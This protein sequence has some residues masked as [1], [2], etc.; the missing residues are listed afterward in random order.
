VEF[1]WSGVGRYDEWPDVS[2]ALA[3]QECE[4]SSR[5]RGVRSL[6]DSILVWLAAITR[7]D[8]CKS[9]QAEDNKLTVVRCVGCQ[10][11]EWKCGET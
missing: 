9:M 4:D 10:P 11:D 3:T 1:R 7:L 5:A 6:Q 8:S 2:K